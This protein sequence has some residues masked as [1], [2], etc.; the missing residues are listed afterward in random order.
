MKGLQTI[1][2]F[3]VLCGNLDAVACHFIVKIHIKYALL[4][5]EQT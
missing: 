5:E 1:D 3:N 4:P 2:C